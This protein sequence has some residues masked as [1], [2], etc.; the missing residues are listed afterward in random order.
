MY[1]EQFGNFLKILCALA[2]R[3]E[4]EP[5]ENGQYIAAFQ[6]IVLGKGAN[7]PQAEHLPAVVRS[8]RSKLFALKIDNISPVFSS[9]KFCRS[10]FLSNLG[11]SGVNP[12]GF[13]SILTT[14]GRKYARQNRGSNSRRLAT[15]TCVAHKCAAHVIYMEK[16][17]PTRKDIY[18][19]SFCA[20]QEFTVPSGIW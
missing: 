7:V 19:I 9:K 10:G 8:L 18:S 13:T 5:A 20:G 15:R 11:K 2:R 16:G 14:G 3:R 1:I 17:K 12:F 6:F 4:F